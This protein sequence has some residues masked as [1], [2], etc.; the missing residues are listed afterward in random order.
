MGCPQPVVFQLLDLHKWMIS[1]GNSEQFLCPLLN[2][3]GETLGTI[4]Y[5]CGFLALC[6]HLPSL[7]SFFGSLCSSDPPCSI[8]SCWGFISS[9]GFFS[10]IK[11]IMRVHWSQVKALLL[12]ESK[13]LLVPC[14]SISAL[15]PMEW[16]NAW[17]APG[18][19][20][21]PSVGLGAGW[22]EW[23]SAEVKRGTAPFCSSNMGLNWNFPA[24]KSCSCSCRSAARCGGIGLV[25]FWG[26]FRAPDKAMLCSLAVLAGFS[27]HP[28]FFFSRS[29]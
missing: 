10:G 25:V 17:V 15:V 6:G 27:P 5:C 4:T 23:L 20:H 1:W 22:D 28:Q 8:A 7:Y 18:S 16:V 19:A 29:A 3:K 11:L 9:T 13:A 14:V 12:P 24:V 2:Y 21:S 26:F